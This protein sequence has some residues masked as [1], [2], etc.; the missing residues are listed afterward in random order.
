MS[1]VES[2]LVAAGCEGAR[3]DWERWFKKPPRDY[4]KVAW[5]VCLPDG[6]G[7]SEG[8]R[9][10]RRILEDAGY[11]VT[12]VLVVRD[13]RDSCLAQARHHVI[14]GEY[15]ADSFNQAA[16][17]QAFKFLLGL[18]IRVITFEAWKADPEGQARWLCK[19]LELPEPV[20]WEFRVVE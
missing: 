1:W 19:S 5:H 4:D 10:A 6:G 7:K 16:Y 3:A 14:T 2:A 15:D 17:Q 8:L 9:V 13:W 20:G 11:E 12:A 18:P